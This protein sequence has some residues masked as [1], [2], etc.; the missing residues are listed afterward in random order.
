MK[1]KD[2]MTARVITVGPEAKVRDVADLLLRHR[3]SAVPV[4][5]NDDR[6]VGIVSEGDLIHRVETGT[7]KRPRSWWLH[8]FTD[9]ATLAE[10]YVKSHATKVAD[11]MTKRV[12]T[13]DE[14]TD[15]TDIAAILEKN[16]IKRVPVVRD[17]RVVGIVSR[18]NLIQGLAAA[19]P[20]MP[21]V[22]GDDDQIRAEILK[23]IESQ[24][25]S[26][27]GVVNVTVTNGVVEIWGVYNSDSE[28]EASR[29]AAENVPGVREVKDH[30]IRQTVT[31]SYV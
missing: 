14:Q 16:H 6:L 12:I 13:V 18:A 7:E 8:L 11:V 30:R 15:L 4:V 3:I 9:S 25:W 23:A 5:D 26:E 24:P 20:E 2:V 27:H 22:N 10:E 29:V 21:T 17:G 28:R 31:A 1:A 19:K